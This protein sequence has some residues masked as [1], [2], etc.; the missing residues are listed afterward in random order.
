VAGARVLPRPDLLNDSSL[1]ALV[2]QIHASFVVFNRPMRW[3][4]EHYSVKVLRD[5]LEAHIGPLL[6]RLD[7]PG[8]L[9]LANALGGIRFLP[10]DKD[11]CV[12]G[13]RMMEPFMF[14]FELLKK[15]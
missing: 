14:A 8:G 13:G 12:A 6:E 11:T 2:R 4:M 5:R 7:V 15:K 3:V 10:V 9:G 1:R